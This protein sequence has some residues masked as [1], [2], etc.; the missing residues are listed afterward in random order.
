M[1]GEECRLRI[2]LLGGGSGKRLW[3]LSNEIRSKIFLKVLKA[4]DGGKESMIQRLCRQLDEAGLLGS[5]A[6]VAHR[7]QAEIVQNHVGG[8][9]PFIAETYRRGTYTAIALAAS[10]LHTEL[11]ADREEIVCVLPAD[12]FVDDAFFDVLR[13][14]P[15]VLAESGARLALLGSAPTHPSGQFG[16]IVPEQ[17]SSGPATGYTP[18]ARFVEKPNADDARLLISS[19]AM[20]NCGVYA[21]S[22]AFML[23]HLK[24]TGLPEAYDELAASCEHLPEASFDV[25]VSENTRPS[26]VIPYDGLWRDLGDWSVLPDY[27]GHQVIGHGELSSD[28]AHT[29]IVN[30]LALPIHVIGASNLIVA[31]SA[32]GILVASKDKSN[33]IKAI[34]S[35][36]PKPRYEEKRWGAYLILDHSTSDAQSETLTKKVNLL[37]GKHTSYHVHQRRKEIWTIITGTGEFVL[38]AVMTGF[39]TGDILQIPVGAGHAVRAITQVEYLVVQIGTELLEEDSIRLA[40]DWQEI[41][42]LCGRGSR[43][44]E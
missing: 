15:E 2:V 38:D 6:I 27:V 13:K 9:I 36:S 21:F 16:Y 23:S 22:L 12:L 1:R 25:E 44:A 14:L 11:N 40:M 41:V 26:V 43:P 34:R 19:H 31:A 10:Y 8:S 33:Q 39:Q 30:E 24:D 4:G 29:H 28:S 5:T 35:S 42:R 32:D 20:W 37:P 18:I 7:N 3:P 17:A